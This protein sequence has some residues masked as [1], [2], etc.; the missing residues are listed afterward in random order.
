MNVSAWGERMRGTG[1]I[2][3]Q[4]A[5]LFKVCRRRAGL[6]RRMPECDLSLF[7]PPQ[8]ARGQMRLL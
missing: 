4:T 3:E 2:A 5:Q 8:P 7:K 6:D 1:I